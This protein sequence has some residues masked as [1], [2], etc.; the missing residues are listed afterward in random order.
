MVCEP[1]VPSFFCPLWTVNDSRVYAHGQIERKVSAQAAIRQIKN[2]IS[3]ANHSQ[4]P[5]CVISSIFQHSLAQ[6]Q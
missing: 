2:F 4:Y 6:H 5:V 3:L 1:F